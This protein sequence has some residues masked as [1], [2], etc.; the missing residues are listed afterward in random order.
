MV[1]IK[2]CLLGLVF[3]IAAANAHAELI[4]KAQKPGIVMKAGRSG[5]FY[6][7]MDKKM[8]AEAAECCVACIVGQGTKV[9]ITDHGF[10]SHTIRVLEGKFRGCVGDMPREW[11]KDCE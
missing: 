8:T 10:A 6:S 11:V 7:L 1:K 5:E 2:G 9:I 3:V 4:C